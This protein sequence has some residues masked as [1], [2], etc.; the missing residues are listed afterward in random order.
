[1]ENISRGPTF[2]DFVTI[3]TERSIQDNM[4]AGL[5]KFNVLVYDISCGK[6]CPLVEYENFYEFHWL[7]QFVSLRPVAYTLMSSS[8]CCVN[9]NIYTPVY[10]NKTVF[11]K[12]Y[13]V[14]VSLWTIK[15]FLS[16]H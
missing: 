1:M 12:M 7:A 15:I 13:C 16:Q 14:R 2:G 8:N 9:M 4:V 5:F 3:R 6:Y 11:K 10:F